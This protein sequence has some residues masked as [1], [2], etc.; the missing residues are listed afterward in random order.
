MS[1]PFLIN[2]CLEVLENSRGYMVPET[3][4]IGHVNMLLGERRDDQ[5]IRD[6][7]AFAKDQGWAKSEVDTYGRKKW[8]ITDAGRIQRKNG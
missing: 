5:V 4:V 6:A 8:W 3:T 1:D 7:L 2:T